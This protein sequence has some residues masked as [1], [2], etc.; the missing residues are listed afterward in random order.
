MAIQ[1]ENSRVTPT[2]HKFNI[3]SVLQKS[4]LKGKAWF[5]IVQQ[6]F[7]FANIQRLE[8]SKGILA[9]VLIQYR[10]TCVLNLMLASCGMVPNCRMGGWLQEL[11][12]SKWTSSM[13]GDPHVGRAYC[14]TNVRSWC[15]LCTTI[16]VN[17]VRS[18]L[19][20][21]FILE[22]KKRANG[23]SIGQSNPEVQLREI[24]GNDSEQFFLELFRLGSKIWDSSMHFLLF[25][26]K[27]IS[28]WIYSFSDHFVNLA[29]D[30]S[31]GVTIFTEILDQ[32]AEFF[33]EGSK[34]PLRDK[35]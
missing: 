14:W 29:I 3:K 9:R 32:V 18:E 23:C 24:L 25:T 2:E 27:N 35:D 10:K 30:K 12:S 26:C 31:F 13:L 22:P 19:Q 6:W 33:V 11:S 15:T 8:D 5:S 16:W 34:R 17:Y 7:L 1:P 28:S 21:Q 20:G 4:Y